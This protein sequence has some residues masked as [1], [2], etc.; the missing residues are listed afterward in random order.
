M[1]GIF[2]KLYQVRKGLPRLWE[3]WTEAKWHSSGDTCMHERGDEKAAGL[4]RQPD[5]TWERGILC[6]SDLRQI[7]PRAWKKYVPTARWKISAQRTEIRVEWFLHDCP[8]AQVQPRDTHN[9]PPIACSRSVR[10]L[11]G[12][13]QIW[14]LI[15]SLAGTESCGTAAV[16]SCS[17][18]ICCSRSHS[19]SS[20]LGRRRWAKLPCKRWCRREVNLTVPW[21]GK[22]EKGSSELEISG[23]S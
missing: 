10:I 8:G 17:G 21:A 19:S 22:R 16:S 7:F 18:G 4:F 23:D 13:N 5:K 14:L 2:T 15:L 3:R 6:L 12:R 11:K 9:P 20:P 1:T